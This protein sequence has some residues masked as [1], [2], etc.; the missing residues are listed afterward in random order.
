MLKRKFNP[1]A[2]ATE[3]IDAQYWN[4]PEM[5]PMSIGWLT[6]FVGNAKACI[7]YLALS[8]NH[9]NTY[10]KTQ[11]RVDEAGDAD[12]RWEEY[13]ERRERTR[14]ELQA[15]VPHVRRLTAHV[16]QVRD[17]GQTLDL[18]LLANVVAVLVGTFVANGDPKVDGLPLTFMPVWEMPVSGPLMVYLAPQMR[19]VSRDV[20][21][22][23]C[24]L[25]DRQDDFIHC[26][27]KATTLGQMRDRYRR[28]ERERSYLARSDKSLLDDFMRLSARLKETLTIEEFALLKKF[29]NLFEWHYRY[30]ADQ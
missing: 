29:G 3:G 16:N 13:R 18:Q 6:E 24:D 14:N 20:S 23:F 10:V 27:H 30:D 12:W 22:A 28:N 8:Y 5:N 19:R 21:R 25:L 17:G 11:A 7:R 2:F 4:F 1:L 9:A 26:Y 15:L